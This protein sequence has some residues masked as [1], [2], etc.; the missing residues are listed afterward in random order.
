MRGGGEGTGGRAGLDEADGEASRGIH[1]GGAPARQHEK[2][3][4][5]RPGLG[6]GGLDAPEVALHQA[7]HVDVRE[8]GG[9]AFVLADLAGDLV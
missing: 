1:G 7:L 8:G 4:C 3:A 2:E 9:G 6:E 5:G